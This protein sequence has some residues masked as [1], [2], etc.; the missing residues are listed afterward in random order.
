MME[1]INYYPTRLNAEALDVY[2]DREDIVAL[3][4]DDALSLYERSARTI[5]AAWTWPRRSSATSCSKSSTNVGEITSRTWTTCAT[6]STG[7]RVAQHGPAVRVAKR[8]LHDVRTLLGNEVDKDFV[9]YITHVE[10]RRRGPLSRSPTADD[11]LEGA[12]TNAEV[13]APGATELVATVPGDRHQAT[14]NRATRL[15]ATIRAGVV[16]DVSSSSAMADPKAE[17]ALRD[18]V[19]TLEE[20]E[21]RWSAAREYLKI[22]ARSP[23]RHAVC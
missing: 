6:A 11:G 18:A 8:G 13:V 2:E 21:D 4:V 1:L 9:R 19:G 3:A 5:P 17:N 12:V 16:R 7:V 15:G 10:M 14:Q 22:D 23:E 20:L